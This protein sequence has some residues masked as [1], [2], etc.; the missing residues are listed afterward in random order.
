MENELFHSL[1]KCAKINLYLGLKRLSEIGEKEA[2]LEEVKVALQDEFVAE[3]ERMEG[4]L[5][6]RFKNGQ[7]FR[8]Q[9]A[10]V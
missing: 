6:M 2:L 9:I 10:E 1:F 4:V 7:T 8:L 3:I 5:V